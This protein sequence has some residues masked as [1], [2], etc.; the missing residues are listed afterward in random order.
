M[1][2]AFTSV[3]NGL[4]VTIPVKKGTVFTTGHDTQQNDIY[5]KETQ[6]NDI[7]HN[8]IRHKDTQ[9]NDTQHNNTQLN[10]MQHNSK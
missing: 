3:I 8:G 10:D 7:Q 2:V 1:F 9:H 4:S 5:H 6:H